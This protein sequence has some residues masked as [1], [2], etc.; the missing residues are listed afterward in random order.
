MYV[1]DTTHTRW[2]L[3]LAFS[4]QQ[5]RSTCWHP[6]SSRWPR[7]SVVAA[8]SS[9]WKAGTTCSRSPAPLP[10]RS[11][12]SLMSPASQH[13]LMIQRYFS[14]SRLGRSRKQSRRP[15][16]ST[17]SRLSANFPL[18]PQ[19]GSP[20]L[21]KGAVSSGTAELQDLVAIGILQVGSA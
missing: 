17:H 8:V 21:G 4:S 7:N 10:T 15:R 20:K 5:A 3:W 9:S 11:V 2:T 6:A 1:S 18:N 13:S 16:A 19:R 14:K 12:H